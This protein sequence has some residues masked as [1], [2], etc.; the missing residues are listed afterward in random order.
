MA[1][2]SS[3]ARSARLKETDSSVELPHNLPKRGAQ[4]DQAEKRKYAADV[5]RKAE[6]KR[7][8][9]LPY[10][11][12]L[13]THDPA[14]LEAYDGFYKAF[15]LD[16]RSFTDKEREVVWA[17]LLVSGREEYGDIH[18]RRGIEVG[19]SKS[20]LQ[21]AVA[22]A[23]A[24][25]SLAGATFASRFWPEWT[26]EDGIIRR[27]LKMVEAARGGIEPYLAEI[28]LIVCHAA[29]KN[30]QGMRVHLPRAFAAGASAAKIAEGV[31]YVLLPCGGPTLVEACATWAKAAEDG[32]CQGPYE[33]GA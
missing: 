11:K 16:R 29:R 28:A 9:L 23:A 18:M 31:S 5:L 3:I 2:G 15:T 20:D 27:Y 14:L 12:M 1:G 7:G 8:Y 26:P 13:G 6:A 17:A 10:H 19:L 4:M 21:D 30:P 24:A 32:I 25:E 22:L 33:E